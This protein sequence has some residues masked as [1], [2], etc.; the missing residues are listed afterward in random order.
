MKIWSKIV[1]LHGLKK[2]QRFSKPSL[3]YETKEKYKIILCWKEYFF[4]PWNL[5]DSDK[6]LKTEIQIILK[7]NGVFLLC[8]ISFFEMIYKIGCVK[9]YLKESIIL[10][11]DQ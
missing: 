3:K 6:Y 1:N 9:V 2:S 11:Y 10:L 8:Q 4:N 5:F 7:I